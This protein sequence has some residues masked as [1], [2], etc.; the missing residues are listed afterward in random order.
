M[1]SHRAETARLR[2]A[3]HNPSDGDI[4]LPRGAIDLTRFEQPGS[5]EVTW[6]APR[7]PAPERLT[8]ARLPGAGKRVL[9][10]TASAILLLIALPLLLVCA[11]AVKISSPGPV[12]FRQQRGGRHGRAITVLKFRTMRVDAEAVLRDLIVAN[13]ASQEEWARYGSLRVDPRVAGPLGRLLRRSSLDEL[14]QLWNVLRGDMSMIG[15]RPLDIY[16]GAL[17]TAEHRQ[18]REA[19]RPGLSGL[20]QVSG[21]A[22]NE[23]AEMHRLDDE[24]VRSWTPRLDAVIAARTVAT[25]ISARGAR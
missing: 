2:A 21:R 1:P 13:A 22:D 23:L 18:V 9:D 12:L 17:I 24:Y 4:P 7:R 6:T 14:P 25:V 15:P 3:S 20:W 16:V 19:V 5:P 8:H 11:V 10:V